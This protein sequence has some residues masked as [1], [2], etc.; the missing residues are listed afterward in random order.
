MK[1]CAVAVLAALAH[2][3]SPPFSVSVET[4]WAAPPLVLEIL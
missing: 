4:S 2:A 3:A 1:W